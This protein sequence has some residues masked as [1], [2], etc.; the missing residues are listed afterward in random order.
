ME[1]KITHQGIASVDPIADQPI[2]SPTLTEAVVAI[3]SAFSA[4][5]SDSLSPVAF[6]FAWLYLFFG[7][8]HLFTLPP[9]IYSVMSATAFGTAF[10][11]LGLRAWWQRYPAKGEWAHAGSVLIAA[12][13]GFNS[14]MHLFLTGDVL[15]SSNLL[16]LVVGIGF[17]VL[18][19]AW[20]FGS[21][22]A[23]YLCWGAGW[24][25][26]LFIGWWRCRAVV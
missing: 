11:L 18:S 14:G 23:I 20:L 7:F 26:S 13:I 3:A 9:P 25:W 10:I 6:G 16:L 21:L 19:S 24:A 5:A 1:S 15:Q 4:W 8:S 2:P 22:A 12:L 17:F